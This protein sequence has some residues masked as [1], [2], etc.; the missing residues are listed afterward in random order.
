VSSPENKRLRRL[1]ATNA[2]EPLMEAQAGLAYA[3]EDLLAAVRNLDEAVKWAGERYDQV[4]LAYLGQ[5]RRQ[6]NRAIP[7][8]EKAAGLI[9]CTLAGEKWDEDDE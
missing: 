7:R 5:I 8:V 9:R 2:V 4:G 3:A 1:Q 6:V